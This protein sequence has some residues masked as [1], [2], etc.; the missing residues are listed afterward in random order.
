M[1]AGSKL[2]SECLM[3]AAAPPTV[4]RRRRSVFRPDFRSC[5]L[6][7]FA[8]RLRATAQ[9]RVHVA[10]KPLYS[11]ALLVVETAGFEPATPCVQSR[12]SPTELRP[13]DLQD[14]HQQS[15]SFISSWYPCHPA[16]TKGG[17][18]CIPRLLHSSNLSVDELFA[19]EEYL[20]F[21]YKTCLI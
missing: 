16:K 3:T 8:N 18:G 4:K 12:C 17:R 9:R 13:L 14:P 5:R 21:P 19:L 20:V 6:Q 7:A 11:K 15:P 2:T 1:N 10:R